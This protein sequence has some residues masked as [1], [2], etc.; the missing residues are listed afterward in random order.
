MKA[1]S[2]KNILPKAEEEKFLQLLEQRFNAQ[3]HL[4]KKI[5]WADVKSRLQKRPEKLY[6]IHQMEITGG[7]PDVVCF[8][9]EDDGLFYFDCATE[10]P[11]ERRSICY[12]AEALIS[13]KEHKPRHSAMGMAEEMGVNLLT[14]AQYRFLQSLAAFDCKTS[15]WIATPAPIRKLGGALFCDRRYN[16]VFTYHNGAESYY[17][18]RGF[19]AAVQL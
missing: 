5:K 9:N 3:M 14:E 18:A 2:T 8:K 19:R 4:H 1:S 15:S 12:D 13:R 17:A 10:T 6:A 11:K 7:E 16:A